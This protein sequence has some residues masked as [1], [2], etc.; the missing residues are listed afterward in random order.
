MPAPDLSIL[1]NLT[2][3]LAFAFAI[4]RHCRDNIMSTRGDKKRYSMDHNDKGKRESE[5]KA[6]DKRRER[7]RKKEE[8]QRQE[9]MATLLQLEA[10]RFKRAVP[11][12][13]FADFYHDFKVAG[14]AADR[15]A[16]IHR[17]TVVHKSIITPAFGTG[18]DATD[19]KFYMETVAKNSK[20]P[21]TID[22]KMV[23]DEEWHVYL[24]VNMPQGKKKD[25]GSDKR[26]K[27]VDQH[28]PVHLY[29]IKKPLSRMVG[30]GYLQQ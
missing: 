26:K 5:R 8:S 10:I 22:P 29:T 14:T 17:H 7:E 1:F 27:A 13:S 20:K 23:V 2:F 25:A 28:V 11:P 6:A 4:L 16:V 12:G 19:G 9:E 21:V 3:A 15:D 18:A 30:M 24:M